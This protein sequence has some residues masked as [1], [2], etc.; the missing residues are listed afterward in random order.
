LLCSAKV[1]FAVLDLCREYAPFGVYF[2]GSTGASRYNKVDVPNFARSKNTEVLFPVFRD[3]IKEHFTIGTLIW[4]CLS[5]L[6]TTVVVNLCNK[7]EMRSFTF[8]KTWTVSKF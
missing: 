2:T 4:S 8:S 6:A 1:I 7:F 5:S 3:S